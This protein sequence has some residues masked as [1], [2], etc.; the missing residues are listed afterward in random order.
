MS[1]NVQNR[2]RK[3]M[4]LFDENCDVDPNEELPPLYQELL[5]NNERYTDETFV[6]EGGMKRITSVYDKLTRRNVAM[7]RLIKR[8]SQEL[9]DPFIREAHLTALLTHPNI[10]PVYDVGIGP[11]G[12]PFFTMELKEGDSLKRIIYE[13]R[14]NNPEYVKNYPLETRLSIFSKICDAIAY[15]HSNLVVHLDLKPDNIQVG[16]FGEVLVCDWGLGKIV[17]TKEYDSFDDLMFNPDFLNNVTHRGTIKGTPGFMAPEQINQDEEICEST[18]IYAL[19]CLLYSLIYLKSPFDSENDSETLGNNKLGKFTHDNK[20][21]TPDGL[22]AIINKCM[23][24]KPYSRYQSVDKIRTDIQKHLLGFAT[25]AENPGFL[26]QLKL[27]YRRNKIPCIMLLSFMTLIAA[28]TTVYFI[29]IEER[30]KEAEAARSNAESKQLET[31]KAKE[32]ND[33]I[34]KLLQKE[35]EWRNSVIQD[36]SNRL[37]SD[38]LSYLYHSSLDKD[39]REHM[40]RTFLYLDRLI[41]AAPNNKELHAKRARAHFMMQNFHASK[42]DF[43]FAQATNTKNTEMEVISNKY[44]KLI[45]EGGKIPPS[46]I[47]EYSQ[48]L[49]NLRDQ[50]VKFKVLNCFLIGNPSIDEKTLFIKSLIAAGN[51]KWNPA[52]FQYHPEVKALEISGKSLRDIGYTFGNPRTRKQVT[53]TYFHFLNI[54]YLKIVDLE[55]FPKHFFSISVPNLDLSLSPVKITQEVLSMKKLR[56]L[57]LSEKQFVETQKLKIPKGLH[58]SVNNL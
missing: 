50:Y 52:S 3:L 12:A 44:S 39:P 46:L 43:D 25:S 51:S 35:K 41:E 27:F 15:S 2:S 36:H 57:I 45:D 24:L 29:N 13:L 9:Y 18:D 20:L 8:A 1:D 34:L 21:K 17:G 26:R 40:E 14:K 54:R 6:A 32:K 33:S 4:D 38:V 31:L 48:D 47:P 23:Q 10:I 42:R 28:L 11:L 19:G 53:Q 55:S 22:I 16:N 49:V 5:E 30:R 37:E 58:I 56:N 7:A